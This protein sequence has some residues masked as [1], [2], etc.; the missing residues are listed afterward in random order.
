MAAAYIFYRIISD[1]LHCR[2]DFEID[3]VEQKDIPN[4]YTINGFNNAIQYDIRHPRPDILA[5]TAKKDDKIVA[6]AG[7]SDDCEM[8]WQIGIDVL[9]D[10]RN[11]GL[12][13]TLTNRLAIEI[14]KRGKIPYYGTAGSN[15]ASQRVAHRAGFEIA[16]MCA[17]KGVF[18]GL[19]TSP[20]G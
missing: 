19:P 8:L 9:P 15:V 5:I 17:Y 10:Y 4:L 2:N 7:A 14:L 3:F 20:T 16:W 6:M 11:K 12:A 18:D 13:A 1:R